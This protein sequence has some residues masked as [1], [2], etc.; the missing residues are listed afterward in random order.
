[1]KDGKPTLD[2]TCLCDSSSPVS[3]P[4]F[5]II[6]SNAVHDRDSSDEGINDGHTGLSESDVVTRNDR[7]TVHHRGRCDEAILDRHCI[8][9]FA[10]VRQQ[11]RPFQARVRIPRKAVKTPDP[12]V[13]SVRAPSASF[14][15]G[16]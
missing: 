7:Q 15:G 1:M 11:F 16:G 10:K 5:Q 9:D 14:P 2:A 4:S 13:T 3:A 6:D 8:P 12:C